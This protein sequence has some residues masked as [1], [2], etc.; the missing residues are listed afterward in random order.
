M[1]ERVVVWKHD[2]I[3]QGPCEP[4]CDDPWQVDAPFP[5]EGATFATQAEATVYARTLVR[6][7][8]GSGTEGK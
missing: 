1:A 3:K 5:F 7:P 4:R 8:D 6:N 2:C